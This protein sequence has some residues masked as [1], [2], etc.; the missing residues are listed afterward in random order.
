[1]AAR[2]GPARA[3]SEYYPQFVRVG[4]PPLAV[5]AWQGVIR[6]FA[7]CDQ[8]ELLLLL[9]DLAAGAQVLV[10]G[11]C[12]HHDP[13]CPRVHSSIGFADQVA[14][15]RSE[16]FAIRLVVPPAPRHPRAIAIYPEISAARFPKHPHLFRGGP[17][18][19]L[20]ELS[21]SVEDALC[22]CRPGD[23]EWSW[24]N[25]DLVLLLDFTA[26]YLAKHVVWEKTGADRGGLWIGPHAS[27]RPE[28]LIEELDPFGECRCGSGERYARCC[29]PIDMQRAE[30]NRLVAAF[31]RGLYS[32]PRRPAA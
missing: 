29:R 31:V 30:M 28:D 2:S 21:C 5:E 6:P 18:P 1:M 9:D 13:N 17:R 16:A 25:G 7:E 27:H 32:K 22:V 19:G 4:P 24:R 10:G 26:I 8:N 12:L 20:P 3:I 11:G 15:V 14:N 23:G